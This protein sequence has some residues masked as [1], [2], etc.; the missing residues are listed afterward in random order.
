MSTS[1]IS[2]LGDECFSEYLK[3][4]YTEHSVCEI[5]AGFGKINKKYDL[6][7]IL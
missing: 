2:V 3:L 6:E 7:N 1:T 5:L 4:K